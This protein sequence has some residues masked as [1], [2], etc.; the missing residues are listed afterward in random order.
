M[1]AKNN[2]CQSTW[3]NLLGLKKETLKKA[4][5][6]PWFTYRAEKKRFKPGINGINGILR[7]PI[8]RIP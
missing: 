4:M 8:L 5:E 3:T 6:K 1:I 2:N 7:Y